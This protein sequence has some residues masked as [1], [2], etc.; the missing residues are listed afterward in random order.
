VVQV[1]LKHM[2]F[3]PELN[4]YAAYDARGQDWKNVKI[5]TGGTGM[6]PVC[7]LARTDDPAPAPAP[8]VATPVGAPRRAA[9]LPL[10]CMMYVLYATAR[11]ARGRKILEFE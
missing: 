6:R 2:H 5:F 3:R 9:A 10:P 4:V 8:V 1:Q 7:E 11:I